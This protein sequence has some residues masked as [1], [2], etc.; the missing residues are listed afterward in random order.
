[1]N[2]DEYEILN[3]IENAKGISITCDTAMKANGRWCKRVIT[4]DADE[5]ALY[6]DG[7]VWCDNHYEGLCE[8]AKRLGV[9]LVG[10]HVWEDA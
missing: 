1:M 8:L 7:I 4:S 10:V 3:Q 2:A 9:E 5:D 6:D